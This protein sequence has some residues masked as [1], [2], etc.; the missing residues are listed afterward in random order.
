ANCL[1][2]IRLTTSG[3]QTAIQPLVNGAPAGSVLTT[4]AGHRYRLTTRLY[5]TEI[6]RQQQT[7][8]SPVHPA[9]SGR[10]GSPLSANVRVVLEV[11]DIDPSNPATMQAPSNVLYDGLLSAAP[12]YCA[13]ALVNSPGP[14][15]TINFTR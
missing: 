12:S 5:A 15:C 2:G 10:G 7:Y 13:Y 14:H 9:G 4:V 1:A 6:F 8:F 3:V 11:H